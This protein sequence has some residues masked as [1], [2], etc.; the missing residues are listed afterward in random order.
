VATLSPDVFQ[1]VREASLFVAGAGQGSPAAAV[2]GTWEGEMEDAAGPRAVAVRLHAEGAALSGRLINRTGGLA[3]EVPLK[4]ISFR[5]GVLR[6]TLPAGNSTRVF[7]GNVAGSTVTGT[8]H[9]AAEG[10]AVGR[11]TLKNVP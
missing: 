11:F 3:M 9:A 4:D 1:R 8:L 6:F 10:P 7:V 5:A 2:E